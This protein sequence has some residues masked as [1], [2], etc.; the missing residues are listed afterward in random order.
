[1]PPHARRAF[2]QYLAAS[3][4][5]AQSAPASLA[6]PEDAINVFDFQ[7]AARQ[8]L[9]PAHFGYLQTGVVGD[10]TLLANRTG[11]DRY[12][13]RP[14]RLVDISKVDTSVTLFGARHDFPLLLAPVGN[15]GAFHPEA[16]LP[17]ARAAA[18]KRTMQ[19]L[20]TYTNTSVEAINAAAGRP[21]WY[22]LYT[23]GN[24]AATDRLWRRAEDAGCPVVALTV[25]SQAGRNTE[26][27]SRAKLLDSR[28]CVV[29][30]D[31]APGGFFKR[32]PMLSGINM[33]G[34]PTSNAALTWDFV[35][36]LRKSTKMKLLIKG[37][38]THEDARLALECGVDGIVVSN[39][40][41][42]AEESGR[43]TIECLPE[44]VEAV[45]GKLTILIDGGFRRGTDIYKALALGA[46]A[47]CV[48]RPYI[49]GLAAFGQPGVERVIDLLH[50]E[51]TLIMKQCGKRSIA[52]INQSSLT[53]SASG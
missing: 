23:T 40:G 43:G 36:Q 37:I 52:E 48:G 21:V 8:I 33:A 45:G 15:T 9:P 2:L 17:V 27:L 34:F 29:C 14:R 7:A 32:K 53:T 20:S 19:I 13:L 49:W 24:P 41:G 10:A 3:P 44:I 47:V 22:Q 26:T 42:R 51:F 30:H 25:D 11:F 46:N 4:L 31:P 16:E 5:F 18:A 12:Q 1:M 28:K 35:R 50:T 6:K 38:V 39:H